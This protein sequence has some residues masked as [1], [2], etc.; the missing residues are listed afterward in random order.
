MR[1]TMDECFI[2]MKN[3]VAL[4]HINGG[5][6]KDEVIAMFTKLQLE[7]DKKS[8]VDYDEDLYDGGECVISIS[9][10]NEI[11]QEKID[12]LKGR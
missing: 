3:K 8:I 4:V 9:E 6:T 2:E 12:L 11:I 1:G 10:I 5:Y 7:I